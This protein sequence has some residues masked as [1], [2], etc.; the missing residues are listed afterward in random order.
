VLLAGMSADV[1][2]VDRTSDARL[3]ADA[4]WNF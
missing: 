2:M 3:P 4:A 1:L